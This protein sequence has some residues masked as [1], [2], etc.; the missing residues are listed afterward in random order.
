[1]IP[2]TSDGD[3]QDFSVFKQPVHYVANSNVCK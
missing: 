2:V 1:M 3:L